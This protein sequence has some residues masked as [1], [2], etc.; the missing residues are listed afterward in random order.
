MCVRQEPCV[1][2][3]QEPLVCEAGAMCVRQ[4][5]CVCVRQEPRV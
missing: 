5:P 2:V 4:E 3:K 1:Y